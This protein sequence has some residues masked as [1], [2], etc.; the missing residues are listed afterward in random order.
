MVAIFIYLAGHIETLLE[1]KEVHL[2]SALLTFLVF[3]MTCQDIAV[4]SWAVE[5]LHPDHSS[6]GSSSQST[7]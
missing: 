5:M 3:I 2:V 6:Y 7:G 4:D 1:Q